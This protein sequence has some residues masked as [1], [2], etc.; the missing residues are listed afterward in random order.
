MYWMNQE[1]KKLHL[2]L[3]FLSLFD[4]SFANTCGISIQS[5]TL[6]GIKLCVVCIPVHMCIYLIY[7]SIYLIHFLSSVQLVSCVWLFVIS[8]TAARQIS[9]IHHQLLELAQTHVWQNVVHWRRG[10]QTTSVFLPW[11]PQEQY[12]KAK[13]FIFWIDIYDVPGPLVFRSTADSAK[14]LCPCCLPFGGVNQ[15]INIQK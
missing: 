1:S 6:L 11:E 14:F 3:H 13:G 15:P 9:P 4:V 7:V 12:E 10:W 5:T 2:T 8:M